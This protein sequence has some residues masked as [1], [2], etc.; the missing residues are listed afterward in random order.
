MNVLSLFYYSQ[1]NRKKLT[2]NKNYE[3]A[4]KPLFDKLFCKHKNE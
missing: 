3:T 1:N 2:K 4:V